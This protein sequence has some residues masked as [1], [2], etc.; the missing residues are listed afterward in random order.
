M[1]LDKSPP[2]LIP[3]RDCGCPKP[4]FVGLM[5]AGLL[6]WDWSLLTYNQAS[7]PPEPHHRILNIRQSQVESYKLFSHCYSIYC[8]VFD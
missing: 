8:L 2:R 4:Y 1:S 7:P 3:V 6:E 5:V